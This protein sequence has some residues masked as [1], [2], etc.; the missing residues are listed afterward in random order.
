MTYIKENNPIK[1]LF[2]GIDSS[3]PKKLVTPTDLEIKAYIELVHSEEQEKTLKLNDYIKKQRYPSED[4]TVI[5]DLTD[6][7][8]EDIEANEV[9]NLKFLNFQGCLFHNTRFINCDLEGAIFRDT[10]LDNVLF[11]ESNINFTDFRGADLE[12]CYFDDSYAYKPWNN[13]KG[14]KLSHTEHCIRIHADIKNEVAKTNERKRILDSK[15]LELDDI[16]LSTPISLKILTYFG[17]ENKPSMYQKVLTEFQEMERGIFHKKNII[18]ESFQNIFNSNLFVF[19]PLYTKW[20]NHPKQ[21]ENKYFALTKND[22]L[23]YLQQTAPGDLSLNEFARTKYE[24]TLPAGEKVSTNT[25]I[26]ADL[27]SKINVF[28]NNE[29][30]RLQLSGLNFSGRDLSEV[31]FSGSDLSECNFT[32]SN[33]SN[34]NFECCDLK[35]SIF[36]NTKASDCN[37]FNADL[38]ESIIDTTNFLRSDFSRSS[39]THIL[40]E[41]SDMRFTFCKNSI[42]SGAVIKNSQFDCSDVSKTNFSN[43]QFDTVSFTQSIL[44]SAIISSTNCINCDFSNAS[45]PSV[46]AKY[47]KWEKTNL[48][49]IEAI[50]INFSGAIF[51]GNCSFENAHLKEGIFDGIKATTLDLRKAT[52]DYTKLGF[53]KILGGNLEGTSM[54]FTDINS[55][56]IT[57]SNCTKLDMTGARLFNVRLMNSTLTDSNFYGAEITDS[58]LSQANFSNA[59]WQ[60]LHIKS[61]ILDHIENHRMMI[62]DNTEIIDCTIHDINGQFYHHDEDDFMDIMFIE[63][64]QSNQAKIQ[65]AEKYEKLGVILS[66]IYR[67]FWNKSR[68]TSSEASRLCKVRRDN[69]AQLSNHLRE[70]K[71][72]IKEKSSTT[73]RNI[74]NLIMSHNV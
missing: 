67:L 17:I 61:S 8:F 58:N 9:L 51:S 57:E 10:V 33:I 20:A 52:L 23:D 7:I 3:I 71:K 31:N 65:A 24:A 66:S 56:T 60:N 16:S 11:K 69:L 68:L 47:T 38:S 44:N 40:V 22:V 13:T 32:D 53:C 29:W 55:T 50:K 48:S 54:K 36:K 1:Y 19:D 72:T 18:H 64:Q 43:S 62:N 27:S 46:K 45:M 14:L 35:K 49:N 59:N 41:A 25:K 4:V 5:I 6:K 37:F 15:R 70:I 42:W 74:E 34:T 30:L 12:T 21:L 63:Q 2:T 73:S 39:A 28:G 26:I